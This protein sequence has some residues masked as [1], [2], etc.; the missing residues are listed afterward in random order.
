M[1]VNTGKSMRSG[2]IKER[3]QV[4]NPATGHYIKRDAM[5]GKF[6]DIK[7]DGK[8]FKGVRKEVSIVRTNPN[9]NREIANIAEAAVI[10]VRNKDK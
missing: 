4:F 1:A 6:M 9:L 8:P 10:A 5:T 7:E 3:S 2:A